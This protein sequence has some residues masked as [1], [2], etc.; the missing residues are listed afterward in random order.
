MQY[1]SP[2]SRAPED[3]P[4]PDAPEEEPDPDRPH[5]E[6]GSGGTPQECQVCASNQ[7]CNEHEFIYVDRKIMIVML[8]STLQPAIEIRR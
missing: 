1:S 2:M 4:E 8:T 7:W 6:P 3:E 5:P